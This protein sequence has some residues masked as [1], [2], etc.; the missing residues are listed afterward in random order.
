MFYTRDK[1]LVSGSR[2]V[3]IPIV[4]PSSAGAAGVAENQDRASDRLASGLITQ[5]LLECWRLLWLDLASTHHGVDTGSDLVVR[6]LRR[7]WPPPRHWLV[8]LAGTPRLVLR[9]NA[10]NALLA[11]VHVAQRSQLGLRGGRGFGMDRNRL[12]IVTLLPAASSR[13]ALSC[14]CAKAGAMRPAFTS[15]A[16]RSAISSSDC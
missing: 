3:A 13:S 2:R 7:S 10:T 15:A 4:L 9:N 16:M 1:S 12:F 6:A 5:H 14:I 8:D 11:S